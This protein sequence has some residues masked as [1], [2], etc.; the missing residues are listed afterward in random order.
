VVTPRGAVTTLAGTGAA[1]NVDGG[2]GT[3]TLN[4]PSAIAI[5]P[6]GAFAYVACAG[7]HTIRVVNL[8]SGFIRSFAGSGTAAFVNGLGTAARFNAPE[9]V[10]IM[11]STEMIY[12]ADSGNQR[13]RYAF[14][15]GTV[16][17]LSGSG[18]TGCGAAAAPAGSFWF[19]SPRTIAAS[20]WGSLYVADSIGSRLV[21]V[22]TTT[23][24]AALL[25]GGLSGAC[26]AGFA[27]GTA[28]FCAA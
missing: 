7:S 19:N 14:P 5:A 16:G 12:I 4:N 27:D 24:F 6:S 28:F 20:P 13:V 25:V 15:N 10:T 22:D 21:L 18:N 2:P 8:G 1:G 11:E 9:G 26:N 23:G 17:W 3:G